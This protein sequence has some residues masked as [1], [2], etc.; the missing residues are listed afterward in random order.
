MKE[1]RFFYALFSLLLLIVFGA[2]SGHSAQSSQSAKDKTIASDQSKI[3]V[4][5]LAGNADVVSVKPY[6]KAADGKKKGRLWLD[7]VVKNTASEPQAYSVFG[8]AKTDTGGWLGGMT[9]APKDGKLVPGKETT[10]KVRTSY[11]GEQVPEQIRVE[12]LPAQ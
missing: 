4:K 12:I 7:V 8:Q 5:V 9:E 1:P 2:C 6:I 3:Q 11:E 10:A